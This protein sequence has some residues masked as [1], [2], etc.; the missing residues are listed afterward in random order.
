M[1][2][3]RS[4]AARLLAATLA[5]SAA[6]PALAAGAGVA[7]G[8]DVIIQGRYYEGI[9]DLAQAKA[10]YLDAIAAGYSTRITRAAIDRLILLAQ[11]SGNVAEEMQVLEAAARAGMDDAYSRLARLSVEKNMLPPSL[12]D[13]G[14]A[15]EQAALD[16]PSVAL[17]MFMA[18]L[19]EQGLAASYGIVETDPAFWYMVAAQR[20]SRSG[21]LKMIETAVRTGRDADAVA[22]LDNLAPEERAQKAIGFGKDLARGAEGIPKDVERAA[23]WLAL[24]PPEVAEETYA[25]L[26]R[27][28][29]SGGDAKSALFWYGKVGSAGAV[30]SASTLGKL[31]AMARGKDRKAILAALVASA[32]K[33]DTEAAR[34]AVKI[35]TADGGK[36]SADVVVLLLAAARGGD[37]GAIDQ[38][39][40]SVAS[41]GPDDPATEK[42]M[43]ALESAAK[44]GSVPAMTALAR[45][46]GSGGPVE[47]NAETSLEWYRKA[48]K[49]GDPE[50]QFRVGLLMA[51]TDPDEAQAMLKK[52]AAKGYGPAKSALAATMTTATN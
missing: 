10:I 16:Q 13:M 41:L 5:A 12:A 30:G 31:Y 27:E 25:S 37:A 34:V 46:Y 51:A 52:A 40:R 24:A 11:Q 50:A 28:S 4:L 18:F 17:A 47:A 49:A 2:L 22:L 29:M 3:S 6:S 8:S 19:G 39:T 1:S 48:A 9:G 20:G 43:A 14:P 15:Y 35:L 23:G 7:V 42:T 44:R 38:L 26:V 32:K 45:F 33:G 36:P 21:L